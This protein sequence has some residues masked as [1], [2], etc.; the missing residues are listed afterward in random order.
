[1]DFGLILLILTIIIHMRFTGPIMII[2]SAN[3]WEPVSLVVSEALLS[4]VK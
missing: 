2:L 1:M 3:M 4:Y